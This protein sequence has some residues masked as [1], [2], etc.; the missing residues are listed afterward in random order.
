M[1]PQDHTWQVIDRVK[2]TPESFT[3]VFSPATGSQ[4]FTFTVGQFVTAYF[5]CGD[6]H[7]IF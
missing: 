7:L 5:Y 2:E 1:S 4:K 3:Y 6:T